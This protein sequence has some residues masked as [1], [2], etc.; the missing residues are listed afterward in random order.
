MIGALIA[1][2]GLL[3]YLAC[4]LI[5]PGEGEELGA[6]S[7][8]WL[9]ALA[10]AC[11]TCLGLATLAVL[12]AIATLFGFGWIAVLL[13][14]AALLVVLVAWPRFNPAWA[15][16]PIAGIALPAVAVAAGGVQFAD[17]TGHVTVA[18]RVLAP[19]G[20]ATF[21]AGLGT[22]LVDLRRTQLPATGTLNVRV[23][24]GVRRTIVALPHDR[25]MHVEMDYSVRPFWSEVASVLAGRGPFRAVVLF[26][27]YLP[28]DSGS[29][30]LTSTI[31]GPV[32]KLHLTSAGGSLYVR[33]YPDAVD[34]DSVPDWPGYPVFVEP[35]PKLHGV[36][37]RLARDEMRSWRARHT[38]EVR[39][40]HFVAQ[41]LP[42]PCTITTAAPR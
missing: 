13:A 34:P 14:A 21:R 40:Q 7:S 19:G 1:G 41:N 33:D 23:D 18:P 16:L 3:A 5:I 15:L 30:K 2:V 27:N 36:S 8:G 10:K 22:M 29:R 25:C 20:V 6:R 35:R 12:A 28:G 31:P 17:D 4:W 39:S 37:K 38:N 42:G 9:V 11:A 24:G 32:L 26:G